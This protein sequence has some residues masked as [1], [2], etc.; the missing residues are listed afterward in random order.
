LNLS[1]PLFAFRANSGIFIVR[2]EPVNRSSSNPWLSRYAALTALATLGLV[3]LGGLVTSHEAGLAV[4]DWPTTYGYNMFFFPISRWTGGVFYE[5]T[6]RLWAS[7]VG[8]LTVVLAAWLWLKESRQW[9]RWT[10]VLAVILVV[11][12]GVLGGLRVVALKDEIGIFH[13]TL[14][15][16]FLVL[17]AC[18]ALWT[19]RWWRE[20][21]PGGCA[22]YTRLRNIF[23][24]VSSLVLCQLALGATMRHQHAGLAISDFP[25]AHGRL[26]PATDSASIA[27]YNQARNEVTAVKDITAAQVWL[28]MAHRGMAV[29]ILCAIAW[30]A[31][32]TMKSLSVRQPVGKLALAWLA[33]VIVQFALGAFTIWTNKSADIATLHVACGATT[34]VTGCLMGLMA[35]RLRQ[36]STETATQATAPK[37]SVRARASQQPA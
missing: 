20:A 3:C 30:A 16:M 1:L 33:L 29:V 13:G 18:I 31:R 25:L 5:H 12:Q 23:F 6:H 11:A 9:L 28:Q 35:H 19:S 2:V 15:Q 14:A 17:L 10:G 4:P 22:D 27:R 24:T 32:Q 8:L 7:L 37:S 26:W 21:T 36:S 34:L